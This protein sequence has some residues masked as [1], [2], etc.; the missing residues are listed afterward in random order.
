MSGLK[1]TIAALCLS[2]ASVSGTMLASATPA[3]AGFVTLCVGQGGDVTVP[4]DLRVPKGKS[5]ELHGTTVTG[6]VYVS[7]G[8]NLIATGTDFQGSVE[9]ATNAYLSTHD[10]RIAGS[11]VSQGGFGLFLVNTTIGGNTVQRAAHAPER[12]NFLFLRD[13]TAEGNLSAN[14]GEVIVRASTV[15]GN[16]A[17]TDVRYLSVHNSVLGGAL[18]VTGARYGAIV[19]DSEIYGNATLTGNSELVQLGAHK[20]AGTCDGATYWG[21][22]VTVANN[23]ARVIVS[24]NIIRGNLSGTGNQPAPTGTHNRVRGTVSG[25]FT[26]LRAPAPQRRSM[27]ALATPRTRDTREVPEIAERRRAEAHRAAAAAGP[28]QLR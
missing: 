21:G 7:Q 28:A 10:A 26:E 11:I 1:R 15:N 17:A 24:N 27:S 20:P 3:M 19:C 12:I 25:Q 9:V 18:S 2:V 14:G 4:G 6:D 5:C 22:N 8:A 13:S 16:L 23:T